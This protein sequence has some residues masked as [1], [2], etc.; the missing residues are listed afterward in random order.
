MS[1]SCPRN[2]IVP[3]HILQHMLNSSD[4]EIRA[5]ALNTLLATTGLVPSGS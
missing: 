1:R 5:A 4:R 2:C 3:P